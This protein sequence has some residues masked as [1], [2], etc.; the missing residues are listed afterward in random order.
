MK[1]FYCIYQ[2]DEDVTGDN[3]RKVNLKEAQLLVDRMLQR[4]EN[5]IGLCR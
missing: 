2:D 4:S 5:F 3:L 1:V